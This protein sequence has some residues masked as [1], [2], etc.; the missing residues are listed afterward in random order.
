MRDE[1]LSFICH[2]LF[3]GFCISWWIKLHFQVDGFDILFCFTEVTL[4]R[5]YVNHF[6][7]PRMQVS[8]SVFLLSESE[9]LITFFWRYYNKLLHSPCSS[10]C[11]TYDAWSPKCWIGKRYWTIYCKFL[12][13]YYCLL[14]NNHIFALLTLLY[15]SLFSGILWKSCLSGRWF[16]N[17]SNTGHSWHR[18][19]IFSAD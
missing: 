11:N 14:L 4:L 16:E 18:W 3:L 12:Y 10:G 8:R 13:T 19:V 9:S 17:L 7:Y 5:Q 6:I 2:G 1:F 15:L